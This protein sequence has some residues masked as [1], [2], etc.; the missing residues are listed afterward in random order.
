MSQPAGEQLVETAVVNSIE[1]TEEGCTISFAVAQD[2]RTV[3]GVPVLLTR[4]VTI[5]AG[6]PSYGEIDELYEAAQ[7]IVRDVL[8]DW[9]QAEPWTEQHDDDEDPDD[10][11]D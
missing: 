10:D 1:F 11:G 7:D 8:E 3:A 6:H 5:P 9:Q 4:T 2:L